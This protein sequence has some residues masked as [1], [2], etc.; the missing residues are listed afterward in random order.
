MGDDRQE[1][2][3]SKEEGEEVDDDDGV[4]WMIGSWMEWDGW[5]SMLD[6]GVG[7]DAYMHTY[8]PA[9]RSFFW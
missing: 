2:R 6:G 1:T 4:G 9:Y 3:R 5:V 8:T 7:G